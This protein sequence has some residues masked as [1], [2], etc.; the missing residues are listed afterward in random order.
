MGPKFASLFLY[1]ASGNASSGRWP[2]HRAAWPAI[3]EPGKTSSVG[4]AAAIHDWGDRTPRSPAQ[5]PRRCDPTS[6][7][8]WDSRWRRPLSA[9][10][11]T[12]TRRDFISAF[13]RGCDDH[14][15]LE[16]KI[17][18]YPLATSYTKE[19]GICETP[20]E[21][22]PQRQCSVKLLLVNEESEVIKH[23]MEATIKGKCVCWIRNTV[24]DALA[25]YAILKKKLPEDC[26][27]LFHARFAL[28]DR[29]DI[30]DAVLTAFGKTSTESVRNGKVLIA[31]QVVEQSLDL[32]FDLL[33]SDLAPMDLLIQRAGR[34][35]RHARERRR[36]DGV[37][38]PGRPADAARRRSRGRRRR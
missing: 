37:R 16:Q 25:G 10:L 35:H 6:T 2:P 22:T 15:R 1:A 31:T 9:T 28:G 13:A 23:I 27:R 11:P 24:H 18:A 26:L 7:V 19:T 29:L 5:S 30:E 20:V 4:E 33:I 34:L 14:Q 17:Q 32:D 3:P 8:R 38:R 12:H 21:A 36:N